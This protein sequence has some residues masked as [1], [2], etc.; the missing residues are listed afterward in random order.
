MQSGFVD[1]F[2]GFVGNDPVADVGGAQGVGLRSVWIRDG[3]DEQ[4]LVEPDATIDCLDELLGT[5]VV[6]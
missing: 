5:W 3:T 1:V 2:V 4:P 6:E